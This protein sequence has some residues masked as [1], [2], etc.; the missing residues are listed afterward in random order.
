MLIENDKK[1]KTGSCIF[2]SEVPSKL[3]IKWKQACIFSFNF[4]RYSIQFDIVH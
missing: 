1:W 3:E 2:L 4:D